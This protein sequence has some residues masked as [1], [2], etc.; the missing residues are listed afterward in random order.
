MSFEDLGLLFFSIL[1][2]SLLLT[3]VSIRF[4]HFVGAVDRPESRSVHASTMPRMGGLGIAIALMVGLLLFV[5]LDQVVLGFLAGMLIATLTGM[6]DDTWRIHPLLKM[7]GQLIACIVFIQI[8]GI[9]LTSFGDPLA[10]GDITFSGPFAYAVTL[11]CLVGVINAFNMSD[12]LD[13]LAGGMAAIVCFFF[14]SFAL[15]SH[16]DTAFILAIS[17]FAATLGFLKYN[18][19]PAR[20]FMGDTGSLMLGY[21]VGC[22]TVMLGSS[23]SDNAIAPITIATVIGLPLVDTLWVMSRRL[24]SGKS[25]LFP[26]NSHVHHRLLALGLSHALVVTI[27]YIWMIIL[28]IFALNVKSL[29]DYLQLALGILLMAIPYSLLTLAER[30]KISLSFCHENLDAE[31]NR[32]RHRFSTVVSRSM[33][34]LLYVIP[35]ALCAPLLVASEIPQRINHL[36]FALAAFVA[37]VFILKRAAEDKIN[38]IHGIFYI[39]SFIILYVWQISSYGFLNLNYYATVFGG[40]LFIWSI[41][42]I[43]LCRRNEV[44]FT[45]SFEILLIFVSWFLPYVMLPA[46]AVSDEVL[47]AAKFACLGAIPLFVAI[48]LVTRRSLD[49]DI[50]AVGLVGILLL[51]GVRSL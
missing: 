40:L 41:V 10:I 1:V 32:L 9:Y 48:K 18:S 27:V 49:R 42:K 7:A 51:I 50:M 29:P 4:A 38:I 5:N 39:C 21:A 47:R 20:L 28:G 15:V 6:A 12:G 45:S 16:A 26:D 37:F 31:S 33:E 8:S 24:L 46:L 14:A 36:A 13:G 43:K 23:N 11:F 30:H 44:L 17:I 2:F 3:P 25:P 34:L 22:L 19:H 35:V